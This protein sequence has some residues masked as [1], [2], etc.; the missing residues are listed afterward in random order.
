MYMSP[1]QAEMNDLDVDTRSDVYALGVML[2]ELLTG[3]T[4]FESETLKK[5]GLDEM[6]RMIRET[7]PPRPSERVSTVAAADRSTLSERRGVDDRQLGR[8]L[9]GELDWVV[10]RCLEKDRT[11]RYETTSALAADVE[12]YLADEPVDACPPS[13]WYGLRKFWWRNRRV[14]RRPGW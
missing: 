1:E 8:Q 12:R 9:R 4:P 3:M 13:A 11:R 7:E 6:R 14:L 5:A 10:M 2:Y